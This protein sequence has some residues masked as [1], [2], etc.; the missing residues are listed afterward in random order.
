MAGMVGVTSVICGS[1]LAAKESARRRQIEASSHTAF[2]KPYIDADA[3]D[4]AG[5]RG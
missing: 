4:V 1:I 5:R 2:E 3:Y